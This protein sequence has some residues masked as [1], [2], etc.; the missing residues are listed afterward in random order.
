MELPGCVKVS[1]AEAG[2]QETAVMRGLEGHSL[3][4]SQSVALGVAWGLYI[5]GG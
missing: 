4:S 3:G 1:T 5:Y 2:A